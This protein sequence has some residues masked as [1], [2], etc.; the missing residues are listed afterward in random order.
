[1]HFERKIA[2]FA[3]NGGIT[4]HKDLGLPG[5]SRQP[6]KFWA[7]TPLDSVQRSIHAQIDEARSS[8]APKPQSRELLLWHSTRTPAFHIS[9]GYAGL[10]PPPVSH[11]APKLPPETVSKPKLRCLTWQAGERARSLHQATIFLIPMESNRQGLAK[12]SNSAILP[13]VVLEFC[14]LQPREF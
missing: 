3:Q 10:R 8:V 7:N 2:V 9:R 13:A 5:K 6:R 12:F 11:R 1:M 4:R 14:F